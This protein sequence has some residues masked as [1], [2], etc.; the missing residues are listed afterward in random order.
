MQYDFD[1]IMDRSDNNSAKY[2]ER[3]K[4][5]GTA[6]V[7]PLWVADMDF[8]T[9]QPIIDALEKKAR[10]GIF[11]YTSR[12]SSYYEA[13]AG[14][15][16]RR[17]GVSLDTNLLSFSPGVVPTLSAIVHQFSEPGD[18]VLIQS[19]VY[20]EFEDAVNAWDRK[21][22][23]CQLVEKD[24]EYTIDFNA[25]EAALKKGP[26][27]FILCHPHNPVGRVW[28]NEELT[29][30]AEL[31]I[32]Y[33]VLMVSDEIH[34]DLMLWG[35]KHRPLASFS[36]EIAAKTITCLSA[37]KTFNLAGLQASAVLF[38]DTGMKDHFE[39]FWRNLDIMRNNSFSV[40]AMEAAWSHGDEWLD[41]LL[42]YLEGNMLFVRD[43]CKERIAGVKANLPQ[44]T[45]LIWLDCRGLG[46][47]DAELERFMVKKAG[48]GMNLGSTFGPGGEGHMRLNAACPRSVLQQAMENLEKAVATLKCPGLPPR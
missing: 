20:Q 44:C 21:V 9:A 22:L 19:P 34:S 40:V 45:Y 26:R 23:N 37:T 16:Q 25:F 39:K 41:Q 7:L 42:P 17:N 27:L 1:M 46:M 32:R 47:A 38:P 6:D 18:M 13:L 15:Q 8:K 14:W 4:K 12:P 5:F 28:K 10:Q 33:G 11:G 36:K 31:C 2:D 43:F 29:R 24:G 35:N 3:L 30:M 48:L